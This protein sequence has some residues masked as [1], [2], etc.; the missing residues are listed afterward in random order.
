LLSTKGDEKLNRQDERPERKDRKGKAAAKGGPIRPLKDHP[1][2][3]LTRYRVDIG[4]RDGVKPG[5]LVGAIANTADID[6]EYIGQI[7]IHD[8]FSTIDLPDGMPKSIL[9]LLETAKV[10]NRPLALKPVSDRPVRPDNNH[11]QKP[12][13]RKASKAKPRDRK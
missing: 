9:K 1:E 3:K 11:S 7:E 13:R 12:R 8:S 4:Y 2:I 6:S 5:N 10:A